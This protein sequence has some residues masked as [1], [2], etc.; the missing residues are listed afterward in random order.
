MKFVVSLAMSV[1]LASAAGA[2]TVT[3]IDLND[4]FA[5]DDVTV[6]A[7]G[8]SALFVENPDFSSIILSNDPGLG[9]PEVIIAAPMTTLSFDYSFVE[10]L[11]GDDEFFAFL[12][13]SVTG[14]PLGAAYQFLT[15]D[16]GSGTV[17]MDISPLTG[18]QL[19]LQF[20]L[21]SL[22][23]DTS[24][25]ST[26]TVSNVTLSTG[27]T[28]GVVPLPAGLPLLLGGLGLFAIVRRRSAASHRPT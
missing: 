16:S 13:D 23:A 4:F 24:T 22:F 10:T 14:S 27:S 2:S 11:G 3:N 6:S 28:V 5:D 21:N 1:F 25:N 12:L 17:N 20:N 7:D 15:T 9:D 19:G 18:G 26:L 8:T